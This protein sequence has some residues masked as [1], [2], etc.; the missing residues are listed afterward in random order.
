MTSDASGYL[1]AIFQMSLDGV[2]GG[3][4]CQRN[5]ESKRR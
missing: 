4:I 3:D 2:G 1:N 5:D